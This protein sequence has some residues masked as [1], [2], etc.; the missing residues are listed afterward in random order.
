MG[1][2]MRRKLIF[3][4]AILVGICVVSSFFA[5]RYRAKYLQYRQKSRE[6]RIKLA[7]QKPV[8]VKKII[9][10][11][12]V[13]ASQPA[14]NPAKTA[15]KSAVKTLPPKHYS[16]K[17][18]KCMGLVTKSFDPI[19][20][21]P[22]FI[23]KTKQ[24]GWSSLVPLLEKLYGPTPVYGV[25]TK[26]EIIGTFEIVGQKVSPDNYKGIKNDGETLTFPEFGEYY[27]ETTLGAFKVLL[28]DPQDSSDKQIMKIAAF[29]SRNATNSM[30]DSRLIQPNLYYYPY[31]RPDKCLQKFFTTDQP[32]L[33]QC[34]YIVDFTAFLLRECGYKTK[35]IQLLTM[36]PVNAPKDK[37]FQQKGHLVL[38]VFLPGEK[39]W[40]M[41]DPDF[42]VFLTDSDGNKLNSVEIF[43][44]FNSS[45]QSGS[46][47]VVDYLCKKSCLRIIYNN[48]PSFY[49]GHRF[50]W[51]KSKMRGVPMVIP[52]LYKEIMKNYTHKIIKIN[53]TENNL[54]DGKETFVRGKKEV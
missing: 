20:S 26:K 30:I 21:R 37:K 41:I 6:Y 53:Y 22:L 29:A 10:T 27:I 31:Q 39:K 45:S 50:T 24:L 3:L 14:S 23:F 9:R 43:H 52:R 12:E 48:N 2:G 34:G 38:E 1:N 5:F 13:P 36:P 7:K 16:D 15:Q 33:L 32:L 42:G 28:L 46:D 25:P 17:M 49:L 47:L 51:T 4:G 40:V 19:E 8:V 18:A 44:A 35:R 11:I 54:W